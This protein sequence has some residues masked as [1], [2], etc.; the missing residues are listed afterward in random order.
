MTMA[1]VIPNNFLIVVA[2]VA[3]ILGV[4]R[5]VHMF[6]AR[7]MRAF[8][9]RW[10]FKYIGPTA[11]PNWLRNP[12]HFKREPPLPGWISHFYPSGERIRQ[13][14]NVIEGK[15]K[16]ATIII[17]D[18]VVGRRGGHPCTLILCQSENNPFRFTTSADRVVQSHGWTVLH[19][20]WYFLFSWTMGTMRIDDHMFC[21]RDVQQN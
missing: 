13:V 7:A 11:P 6:R 1:S 14:W 3:L 9:D 8:A 18:S 17:F 10:G 20:S 19:G 2:M 5:V 15:Q 16:G 21:L 12:V 4:V